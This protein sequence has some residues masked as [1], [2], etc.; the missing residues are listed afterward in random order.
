MPWKDVIGGDGKRMV[1]MG[2]FRVITQ[3]EYEAI[4]AAKTPEKRALEA[5][6]LGHFAREAE[7]MREAARNL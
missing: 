7:A 5:R 3:T 4:E 1:V 6:I 2:D